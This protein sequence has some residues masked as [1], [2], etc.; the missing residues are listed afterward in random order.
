MIN[1]KVALK[2]ESYGVLAYL[3]KPVDSDLLLELINNYYMM[4]YGKTR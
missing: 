1:R 4:V 3:I 2:S